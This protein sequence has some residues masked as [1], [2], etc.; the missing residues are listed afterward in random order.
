MWQQIRNAIRQVREDDEIR[1]I[2]NKRGYKLLNPE[3]VGKDRK[4]EDLK[5]NHEPILEDLFDTMME[6][7]KPYVIF[8]AVCFSDR[9]QLTE[10]MRELGIISVCSMKHER[11]EITK[12]HWFKLDEG[13]ECIMKSVH[14]G[15]KL[16]ANSKKQKNVLLA[17]SSGTGKTIVLAEAMNMRIAHY[18]R[19]KVPLNIIIA[20]WNNKANRLLDDLNEKYF[21]FLLKNDNLK[22][23]GIDI[24]VHV[25]HKS[26]SDQL[27]VTYKDGTNPNVDEINALL[28]SV[29]KYAKKKTLFFLD[30]LSLEVTNGIQDFRRLT[31]ELENIDFFMA[32]SPWNDKANIKFEFVPPESNRILARQLYGCHRNSVQI[33]YLNMHMS[34]G[35]GLNRKKDRIEPEKVPKGKIPLLILKGR[36]VSNGK[37]LR[38]IEEGGYIRKNQGVTVITAGGK[39]DEIDSWCGEDGEQRKHFRWNAMI[40]CEDDAIIIFDYAHAEEMTRA[41]EML[42]MVVEPGS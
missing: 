26:L 25:G 24:E 31:G 27:R 2:I 35:F 12:G 13:Q 9:N 33:Q 3:K 38:L 1:D 11:G 42:I 34:G 10:Y 32:V 41:R 19:Q 39:N 4:D 14:D 7:N 6:R 8:L 20:V 40:G 30:E 15:H 17:G 21:S 36:C 29:S 28:Q 5:D 37:A 22:K 23:N 16:G 18:I